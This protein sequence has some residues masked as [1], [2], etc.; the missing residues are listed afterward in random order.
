MTIMVI[1]LTGG[2]T[3]IYLYDNYNATKLVKDND[4]VVIY[5]D[6]VVKNFTIGEY[7]T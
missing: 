2:S 6:S 5:N 4:H 3:A 7:Q 1:I